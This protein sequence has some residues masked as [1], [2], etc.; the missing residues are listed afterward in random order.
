MFEEQQLTYGQLNRRTNRL[1]HFLRTQGV[2]PDVR[3]GVCLERSVDLVISLLGI[4]KAGGAYVPLDPSYPR[5]RLTYMLA[6]SQCPLLLTFEA[7]KEQ[8][9]KYEGHFFT[10]D[11]ASLSLESSEN[12]ANSIL[13]AN[14]AYVLYTSGSTGKPKGV[15]IAHESVVAFL[16]WT[17]NVFRPQDLTGVLA[18]TSISFDLSVFELF[19]PLSWGGTVLLAQDALQIPKLPFIDRVTLINTVP[20]ALESLLEQFIPPAVRTVNSAGEP[21]S[22]RLVDRIYQHWRN[23]K[24]HDLYGPSE[25]TTYATY[26]LRKQGCP[27]TIGRPLSTTTIY[28][29]DQAS[30]LVPVGV[31]GELSIGGSQLARGYLERPDL[32]AEKFVPHPFSSIPGE[33]LYQTGDRARY[34]AEGMIEFLG[35]LDQQIKI[36]G[37]RI[38]LGEIET[39]LQ[40]Q[41][42]VK[43]AV[44]LL[45][46]NSPDNHQL[47]AYVVLTPGATLDPSTLRVTLKTYLPDYM[48]PAAFVTLETLPL[49]PNGKVDRKAL[50]APSAN[51]HAAAHPYVAPQGTVEKRVTEI[52]QELLHFEEIG[53]HDNFFE[54][55][56]HSLLAMQVIA[57]IRELM[58]TDISIQTLFDCPT[59]A[60]FSAMLKLSEP[61]SPG[62]PREPLRPQTQNGPPPLSFAQKRLWFLEHWEPGNSTYLLP[63]AWR[64]RGSLDRSALNDSLT[65]LVGRHESLRTSCAE[66]D[67]QPAQIIAIQIPVRLP[68]HDF[69]MFSEAVRKA[70]L[71]QLIDE[72]T[73]RPIS[74]STQ[75]LWRGQLIRLD[76]EEHVLLLTLHHIITDGWS[77]GILLQELNTH[78]CAYVT[79]QPVTL[80]TLPIQYTDYAIWQ[81][82]RFQG[83]ELD[84]QLT[85]WNRQL[86][87]APFTIDL[88]T[89]FPRPSHVSYR[90]HCLSNTLAASLTQALNTLSRQEGVT[91]F[92]TLLAAFQL[93]LFR[94]SGQRDLLVGTPIAG[95]THTELENLIGFFVNTLV[96]RTQLQSHDTF[97]DLLSQVRE[98]CLEAYAHQDLPFEKLVEALRPE[99]DTS[100]HPLFQVMFQL[101]QDQLTDSLALP[102]IQIES[103]PRTSQTAKFDLALTAQSTGDNLTLRMEYNT[104]LFDLDRMKQMLEHF[105]ILLKGIVTNPDTHI[106]TLPLLTEGEAHQQ[107]IE[108]NNAPTTYPHAQ[109][110][111]ELFESQVVL[112]PE[113]IAVVY[114]DHHLTY[115]ELNERAYT[116]AEYL[117]E[118][119][120][121]PDDLT[122]ICIERSLEMVIALM[123]ILKAG[124]GYVPLDPVLPKERLAALIRDS[125]VQAILTA[126]NLVSRLS[127]VDGYA[128]PIFFSEWALLFLDADTT[129]QGSFALPLPVQTVHPKNIAYV[130]YTSGSTGKPKGVG[131]THQALSNH[132]HAIRTLFSIGSDDKVL[133]FASLSFDVA[134]EELFPTLFSGATVILR[135]EQMLASIKDFLNFITQHQISILNLPASYWHEWTRALAQGT[136]LIPPAVRQ[137][138]VGSE[139]ILLDQV[140]AWQEVVR[141]DVTL[142]NAY[143]LTET[144]ITT[145]IHSLQHHKNKGVL[146]SAPIGGP[147]ANSQ[148][149]VL[150]P[151]LHPIPIGVNGELYIGGLGLARGYM[152]RADQTAERFLPDPLGDQPGARLYKTGD[153]ARYC[154]DGNIEY[155][156][157]ADHQVKLRGYRIELGEIEHTLTQHP[158]VS[159]SVVTI[160]NTH[161]GDQQLVA[162]CVPTHQQDQHMEWFPCA[163]DYG[164]FD[165]KSDDAMTHDH[166]R[167]TQYDQAIRQVVKDKVVV[168]IG[169]GQ[170]VALAKLCVEAGAKKVFAIE[171]QKSASKQAQQYV[172]SLGLQEKIIVLHG[173]LTQITLPEQ[174]D[175]CVSELIGAVGSSEGAISIINNTRKFLKPGGLM[176]PETCRSM[177]GAV[178]LPDQLA[179]HLL[180][181]TLAS[182]YAQQIIDKIGRDVGFRVSIKNFPMSH[183]VS[184][185]DIFEELDFTN[186]IAVDCDREILLTVKHDGNIDG[187]LVWLNVYVQ[188]G[189]APIDSLQHL[190]H[191]LPVYFPAFYPGIELKAGDRIEAICSRR[192]SEDG[193]N[194]DY[195][196]TGQ[197]SCQG[198]KQIAFEYESRLYNQRL[199]RNPFYEE[200]F[201]DNTSPIQRHVSDGLSHNDLRAY[202]EQRLPTYMCPTLFVMIETLPTT[203]NGKIDR[204][205]LPEPDSLHLADAHTYIAPKGPVEELIAK[206]WQGLLHAEQIGQ[207]DHFFQLGGHSLLATQLLSRLRDQLDID[208]PLRI[209]FEHPTLRN[210]AHAIEE[211]LLQEYENEPETE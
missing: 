211:L 64:L 151:H 83:E 156:G 96:I 164:I 199:P 20:S 153:V 210:Q 136:S 48:V 1:A 50:P 19:C 106:T 133:Q 77:M 129:K 57:K 176:I 109:T 137:V 70:K 2:R 167:T 198:G 55:G 206:I 38:E 145:M 140:K 183:L 207:N 85:Y 76:A 15:M 148:V 6:D 180:F 82:H 119:G 159:A 142:W 194:P 182:S 34:R 16:H 123:G 169:T 71:Q 173:D 8:L 175:V 124:A 135:S 152:N 37:F 172:E 166:L 155:I 42:D 134:A 161:Q 35:R 131:I 79:N 114:D 138:L 5:D 162:Y 59:I 66:V 7:M 90:G 18:S 105:E 190:H 54:R 74:L 89:D 52:W 147:I 179:K 209:F 97:R 102:H 128:P 100:R 163:A 46:E 150:D 9:P 14:L 24:V 3:V 204:Q 195:L 56:G 193:V 187:F 141:T 157:R 47:F 27:A 78:Y 181:G 10:L 94:Y 60:D 61:T 53:R 26:T 49:T 95:R 130:L 115:A 62:P 165:E 11:W 33:R 17:R 63:Y 127:H 80:P 45:R 67:G 73:H 144:T 44:V 41:P 13:P 168:D 110:A 69:T 92:M 200:L 12:L 86:T 203:R 174:V 91:L 65:A 98:T 189:M 72:E 139:K 177:I 30:Q 116:L 29:Q 99:R 101:D 23:E 51:F 39:L 104:D 111:A 58:Q 132:A 201:L 196:I 25:T 113:G 205:A 22:T 154:P 112:T 4:L 170:D 184:T 87:H 40:Q 118:H 146:E 126:Q 121:G 197:I 108:W 93:L 43:D 31:S 36:R 192:I 28:L 88:P 185:V 143:G 120:I 158:S 149:Y 81:Q 160:R 191:W 107:L 208:L 171:R 122:G 125:K 178:C 103:I 186:Q 202:I 75:P 32:T 68:F 188:Q 84:R 117:R 21:L